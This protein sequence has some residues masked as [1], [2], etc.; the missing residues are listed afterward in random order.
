MLAF[1]A[2]NG[3]ARHA[4]RP[5]INAPHYAGK[6]RSGCNIHGN[7]ISRVEDWAVVDLMKSKREQIIQLARRH[8]VTRVRVFGSMA[9]GDAGPQSDVDLLIEVGPD[10]SPWFP[11]GLVAELEELIGRRV[12]VVTERR[13]DAL[14]RDRVLQE[15]VPL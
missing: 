14:L 13:L 4:E 5:L 3:R 1:L 12:Q 15:A 9:R 7:L 6:M 8:G 10:P 11:G 2:L